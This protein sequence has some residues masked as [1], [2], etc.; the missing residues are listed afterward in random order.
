MET[1]IHELTA[2]Y[3]L[4]ALDPEERRAY[5][6]HLPGCPSCQ[7]ELAG[8]TRATDA[9]AIAASGPVPDPALRGRILE[10]A[11]AERQVVVPFEPRRSRLQ[12]AL[13]AVAAAA[14]IVAVAVGLW[15]AQ[16]SGDLDE[17]RS[18][19]ERQRASAAVLADPDARTVS[20]QEGADGRLVLTPDGD[21]VLVVD[22]LG[23]A[24]AGKTYELWV[25]PEGGTPA[26][27]GT[28]PGRDG[29]DIVSVDE[30]VEAGQVVLVTVEEAGGV[31]APT[32]DPILGTMP[33]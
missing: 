11:R 30:P 32:S 12:P 33:A 5:E 23:P 22:D 29:R 8:L 15:A 3:A 26:P 28:F 25:V 27:A 24:P 16:L 13:V 9:L 1:G 6:E 4:D 14:A 17:A 7:E 31:D 19:L 2:A 20:L 18:A 10:Q 21:A